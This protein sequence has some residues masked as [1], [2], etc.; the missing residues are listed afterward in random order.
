MVIKFVGILL[1]I[2]LSSL[3]YSKFCNIALF[4]SLYSAD[5]SYVGTVFYSTLQHFTA[6][7]FTLV[8]TKEG[9]FQQETLYD[10]GSSH[11]CLT[12]T[13]NTDATM[14]N[15][16]SCCVQSCCGPWRVVVEKHRVASCRHR[17]R[18][19]VDICHLKTLMENS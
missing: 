16:L 4:K 14:E 13:N 15:F 9:A 19:C 8:R 18:H 5:F 10:T 17:V 11:P 6:Y 1:C 12:F 7:T 2:A 3:F